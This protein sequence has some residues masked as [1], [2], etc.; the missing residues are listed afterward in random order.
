VKTFFKDHILLGKLAVKNE[1]DTLKKKESI[2]NS[3]TWRQ[4][5]DQVRALSIKTAKQQQGG[6]K[7][8]H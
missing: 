3:R 1:C 6:L 4:I 5:K 8:G 7:A 2:L